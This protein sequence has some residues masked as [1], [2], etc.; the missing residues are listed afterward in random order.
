MLASA[1][2]LAG[3]TCSTA[4][5]F[6]RKFGLFPGVNLTNRSIQLPTFVRAEFIPVGGAYH[7]YVGLRRA[8][9]LKNFTFDKV[10][11]HSP[12]SLLQVFSNRSG[13]EPAPKNSPIFNGHKNHND[14]EIYRQQKF[15]EENYRKGIR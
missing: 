4:L 3:K 14:D 2:L 5:G 15:I 10:C 6:V 9:D 8:P 11:G 13:Q 1:G 12:F 7:F